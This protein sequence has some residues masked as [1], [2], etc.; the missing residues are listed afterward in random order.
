MKILIT[1]SIDQEGIEILKVEKDFEITVDHSLKGDRLA[2]NI[3]PYHA[4]IT[5]SGTDVTA[6]I[7]KGADNLKVIGRAGVG[8][9]NVRTFAAQQTVNPPQSRK[10]TDEVQFPAQPVDYNRLDTALWRPEESLKWPRVSA[11]QA[12]RRCTQS[13]ASA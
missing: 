6:S 13:P 12:S 10:V 4:L 8:V 9:D 7:L 3:G 5:R 2:E 11:P 1:D